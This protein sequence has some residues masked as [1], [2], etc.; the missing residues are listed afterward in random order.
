MPD[1]LQD[2]ASTEVPQNQPI[3]LNKIGLLGDDFS[4]CEPSMATSAGA[5]QDLAC[6]GHQALWETKAEAEGHG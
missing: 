1:A 5:L 3:T 6:V 2:L 4:L